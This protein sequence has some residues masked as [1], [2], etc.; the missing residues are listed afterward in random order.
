MLT[1]TQFTITPDHIKVLRASNVDWD[2]SCYEGAP[3]V[4]LKRPYG[5]SSGVARD[6]HKILTGETI[7]YTNSKR[8][9]L[10]EAESQRYQKLHFEMAIVLDIVLRTGTFEPGT[11]RRGEFDYHGWKRVK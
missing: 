4:N 1:P 11:Y 10:T 6:I 7:G 9:E 2:D 5:N 3:C 8:D